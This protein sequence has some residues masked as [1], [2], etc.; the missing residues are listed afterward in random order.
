[1]VLCEARQQDM[2]SNGQAVREA[3]QGDPSTGQVMLFM[4]LGW[5][6]QVEMVNYEENS[7]RERKGG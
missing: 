1:M 4:R 6:E 7:E 5:G 2:P 3:A